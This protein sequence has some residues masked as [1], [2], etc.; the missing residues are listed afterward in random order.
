MRPFDRDRPFRFHAAH[1]LACLGAAL[2]TACVADQP[3]LEGPSMGGSAGA[4]GMQGKAG[5]AGA[6]A[7]AGSHTG[8]DQAGAG[9]AAPPNDG[10]AGS[11]PGG[12]PIAVGGQQTGGSEPEPVAG[13]GGQGADDGA[14]H[15]VPPC[16]FHSDPAPEPSE[17]GSGGSGGAP[18]TPSITLQVSP[19][20]GAYLA[21]ATGRTLYI[22]G[23]DLPGDCNTPPQSLCTADCLVSWPAFD[24]GPR[25]LPDTLTDA[26]F[27]TLHRPDGGYQT[28][29]MGWPL[30][31]YKS[32]LTLGQVAGQGKGK[33]WHVS[34]LKLPSVMIMKAGALKYLAD[35]AGHTLYVSAAD[36]AGTSDTDPISNCSGSCLGTFEGF[37]EKNLSLVT[38]LD[39]R[40]FGVFVRPGSVDIQIAYKGMPLYR[41]ASDLKSGDMNGTAAIGFTAAVP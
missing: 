12:A 23:A 37:H 20:V 31:Y 2:I 25:V 5:S 17:G 24:A 36:Q 26:G 7:T 41:A 28:T 15:I 21:D 27:G 14:V 1:S 32:D 34:Q 16:A 13:S 19:F 35:V 4:S 33:T 29:Y 30:Y 10:A 38:S 39:P 8:S 18:A 9:G 3:G 22:Y 11:T 6:I 40:D